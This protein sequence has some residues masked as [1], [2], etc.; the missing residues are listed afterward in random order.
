MFHG[1]EHSENQNCVDSTIGVRDYLSALSATP[2]LFRTVTNFTASEFEEIFQNVCPVITSD[3]RST[4]LPRGSFG[5]PSKL[6]PEQRL[7]S[8]VAYLKHD[9]FDTF[10][11]AL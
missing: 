2:Y 5:R 10:E 4:C 6:A 8:F 7:L 1:D 9:N 11:S 3:A